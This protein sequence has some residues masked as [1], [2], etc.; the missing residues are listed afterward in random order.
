M[1]SWDDLRHLCHRLSKPH[2]GFRNPGYGLLSSVYLLL[3]L[4]LPIGHLVVAL[5]NGFEEARQ[6]REYLLFPVLLHTQVCQD[7]GDRLLFTLRQLVHILLYPVQ[8]HVEAQLR[9]LSG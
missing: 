7:S 1:V 6:N 8:C 5:L 4:L 3:E 2:I 9:L